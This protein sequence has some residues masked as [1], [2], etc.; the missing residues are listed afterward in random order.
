MTR[1]CIVWPRSIP[2]AMVTAARDVS[3]SGSPNTLARPQ[4]S[5]INSPN[6]PT[7]TFSGLMIAVD[8][9]PVMGVG[10]RLAGGNEQREQASQ[11]QRLDVPLPPVLVVALDEI[12]KL[13]AA[14]VLHRVVRL[15]VRP[16][17][18]LVDGDDI[19]VF[20]LGIDLRFLDE[21]VACFAA[22]T[23]PHP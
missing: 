14:D 9:A 11:L 17:T 1:P 19:G 16:V 3:A 7:A 23:A 2:S 21:A 5:T 15:T 13:L 22:F 6:S 20:Q 10:D 8:D 18:R 4:S 12:P